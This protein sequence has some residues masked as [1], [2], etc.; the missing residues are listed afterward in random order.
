MR[1]NKTILLVL[2]GMNLFYSQAALAQQPSETT[3]K[4]G[5]WT[6]RC[7]QVVGETTSGTTDDNATEVSA[8]KVCET[9]QVLQNTDGNVIAQ[10]AFG[11]DPVAPEKIVAVFQ[12]PQGTLLSSPVRL[13]NEELTDAI[14][15]SY[16]TC[17]QSICLAR[18]ETSASTIEKFGSLD[19]GSLGFEDRSGRKINVLLSFD[20]LSAAI[21]RLSS[22]K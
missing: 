2:F 11:L 19:R 4:Y 17:I 1:I 21:E 8:K 15:A 12:V 18:A 3:E 7:S 14:D 10:I 22:D 6:Y 20:G 16:F 13:G 5:N 9:L